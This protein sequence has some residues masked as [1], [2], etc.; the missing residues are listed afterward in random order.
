MPQAKFLEAEPWRGVLG[1]GY[2][3]VSG[4]VGGGY[5]AGKAVSGWNP[6]LISSLVVITG[7][8]QPWDGAN[9]IF[10]VCWLF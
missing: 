9:A 2:M 4:G 1:K 10:S 5:T 3:R 7:Q 8:S 6:A